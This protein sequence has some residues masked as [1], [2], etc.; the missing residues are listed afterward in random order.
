MRRPILMFTVLLTLTLGATAVPV[1]APAGEPCC[2]IAAIDANA[3]MVTARE[4]KSGRTFQFKLADART[5][6][7]LK[8]GQAVHADF[9]T[10]T[11][12]VTPDGASPCCA[13]VNLRAP[14]TTPIR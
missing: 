9:K 7:Q 5:L 12:S 1:S 6:G 2:S 11:V 3:R 13:I 10:M 8:V 4:T 14:G